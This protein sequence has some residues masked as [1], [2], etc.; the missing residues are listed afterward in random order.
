MNGMCERCRNDAALP[1]GDL[2]ASCADDNVLVMHTAEVIQLTRGCQF[3]TPWC[4]GPDSRT[5]CA[6]CA[7]FGPKEAA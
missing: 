2:C 1:N 4:G 5:C 6:D 3:G 7:E